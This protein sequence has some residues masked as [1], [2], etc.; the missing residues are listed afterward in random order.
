MKNII[1]TPTLSPLGNTIAAVT[2]CSSCFRQWQFRLQSRE[3]PYPT[4]I[5]LGFTCSCALGSLH[6]P[7]STVNHRQLGVGHPRLSLCCRTLLLIPD[8][9]RQLINTFGGILHQACTLPVRVIG[10]SSMVALSLNL[11]GVF[12][13]LVSNSWKFFL[14][15]AVQNSYWTANTLTH[16]GL[17]HIARCPICGETVQHTFLLLCF[18]T[19]SAHLFS[20]VGLQHFAPSPNDKASVGRGGTKVLI[21]WSS[22]EHGGCG[23]ITTIVCL[24]VPRL[25]SR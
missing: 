11:S 4:T 5:F 7:N 15:L 2:F 20:R 1:A 23:N 13:I 17:P 10:S 18:C 16:G 8:T 14:W 21:H 12:E 22:W 3:L 6:V 24:M 19:R 25:G 9:G